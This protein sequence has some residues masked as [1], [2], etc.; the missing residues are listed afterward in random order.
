MN[1]GASTLSES[2]QN[3]KPFLKSITL[4]GFQVFD[5]IT[6][7]PLGHITLLYGPNSAGKSSVEDGLELF[8]RTINSLDGKWADNPELLKHWRKRSSNRHD[9]SPTMTL[10][11]S[12][13]LDINLGGCIA[14]TLRF[15][16]NFHST[17]SKESHDCSVLL[18]Y[19]LIEIDEY[20][21]TPRF[22]I[23]I[24]ISV[25]GQELLRLET[26][27]DNSNRAGVNYLHPLLKSAPLKHNYSALPAEYSKW[28]TFEDGWIWIQTQLIFFEKDHG[29]SHGYGIISPESIISSIRVHDAESYKTLSNENDLQDILNETLDYFNTSKLLVL[30]N[31]ASTPHTVSASRKVPSPGD[32]TIG[33]IPSNYEADSPFLSLLDNHNSQ[34]WPLAKSYFQQNHQVP[35]YEKQPGL[36]D[37]FKKVNNALSDHLFLDRGY[38]L[39]AKCHLV[40]GL[41]DFDNLLV[42]PDNSQSNYPVIVQLNLI[43]AQ[44]RTYTFEDVGSGLGYVLPILTSIFNDYVSI[45]LLQQP[46]LHLHPALQAAIG[47]VF[48]D[49]SHKN[50]QLIIETHSEHILLR[51]LKRIRQSSRLDNSATSLSINPNDV[52]VVYFDS[53]L[54]GTT[55]VKRLRISPDG[56]FLDLWP[57]GFFAER[58]QELFGE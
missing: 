49:A 35:Y 11:V 32:L 14:G 7:I 45:S 34:Y 4:G 48:I 23:G 16:D 3:L 43:D 39:I 58:D 40:I 8:N 22:D 25:D 30:N 44:G 47:D 13:D 27:D 29:F 54:D 38:Q 55:D 53:K 42:T 21:E 1:P 6:T 56:D 15:V 31:I 33:L 37:L 57:R 52:S 5:K 10:G 50:H 36:D 19:K 46:E 9:L 17:S 20:D 41:E 51:V 28:L 12:A 2:T 24:S 18:T 26:L